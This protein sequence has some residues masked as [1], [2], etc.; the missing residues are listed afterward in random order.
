MDTS[1][2]DVNASVNSGSAVMTISTCGSLAK[3]SSS[4]GH[5]EIPSEAFNV[6]LFTFFLHILE[7]MNFGIGRLDNIA[8]STNKHSAHLFELILSSC[9]LGSLGHFPLSATLFRGPGVQYDTDTI[10][11][12]SCAHDAICSDLRLV[13]KAGCQY[14][15]WDIKTRARAEQPLHLFTPWVTLLTNVTLSQ[16]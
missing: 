8:M 1:H 6:P 13:N 15:V 11:F 16:F 12:S 2:C 4:D 14:N 7:K 3:A 9:D 5:S 10:T